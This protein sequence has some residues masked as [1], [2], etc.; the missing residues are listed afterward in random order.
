[1][2]RFEFLV[3]SAHRFESPGGSPNLCALS[4][5][6]D[7]FLRFTSECDTWQHGEPLPFPTYIFVG[8]KILVS[9]SSS[10]LLSS[11][12]RAPR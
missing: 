6:N 5:V 1:M 10:M 11:P 2:P 3:M 4:P 9:P 8:I 7:R 12:N